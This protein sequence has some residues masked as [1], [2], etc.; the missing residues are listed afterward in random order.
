[1][2]T[3]PFN[4]H[5]HPSVTIADIPQYWQW[6]YCWCLP[7]L[8][9]LTPMPLTAFTNN[10]HHTRNHGISN[11]M[12][13]SMPCIWQWLGEPRCIITSSRSFLSHWIQVPCHC[14]Q[15]VNQ[16]AEIGGCWNIQLL[17]VCTLSHPT[18]DWFQSPLYQCS[19]MYMPSAELFL[20]PVHESTSN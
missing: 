16:G 13:A 2:V 17:Q 3:F 20:P 4:H 5:H 6:F 9:L 14:Q 12:R 18:L 15:C 19:L 10:P 8:M 11:H 1:M 7:L